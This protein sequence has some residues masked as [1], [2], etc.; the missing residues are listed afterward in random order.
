L[1]K[2]LNVSSQ[3]QMAVSAMASDVIYNVGIESKIRDI[4]E[5]LA[6]HGMKV[7]RSK[8]GPTL[9]VSNENPELRRLFFNSN[10]IG[11]WKHS[12]ARVDG[13]EKGVA[14]LNGKSIR[15]VKIPLD[16]ARNDV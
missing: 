16:L 8:V 7:I 15:G 1:G 13:A 3:Y 11:N 2:K 4:K 14:N 10:W 12:L 5:T 9:F 6:V